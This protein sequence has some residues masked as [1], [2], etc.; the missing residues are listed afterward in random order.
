MKSAL[1]RLAVLAGLWTALSVNIALGQTISFPLQRCVRQRGR[2]IRRRSRRHHQP[3]RS[4]SAARHG[5]ADGRLRPRAADATAARAADAAVARA[6][7]AAASAA[8]TT[9]TGYDLEVFSGVE[10]YHNVTDFFYQRDAGF[11]TGGNVGVPVPKLSEYGIGAPVRRR[12]PCRGL[13]RPLPLR[14][15]REQRDFRDAART[16]HDRRSVPPRLRRRWPLV[17]L[18]HGHCL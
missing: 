11:V 1:P 17:A 9:S 18:Q 12:L 16:L 14:R 8:A 6:V 3:L 7:A 13:R 5:G 10:A 15:R 2:F 4:R